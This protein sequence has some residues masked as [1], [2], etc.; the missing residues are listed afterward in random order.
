MNRENFRMRN[1][2]ELIRIDNFKK[3]AH[4]QI[5]RVFLDKLLQSTVALSRKYFEE[6][7]KSRGERDYP[8]RY[9]ERSIYSTFASALS[10]MTPLH[11]SELSVHGDHSK[12]SKGGRVDVWA[13]YR[14]TDFLL[15]I[16][17]TACSPTKGFESK[18]IKDS[19][20]SV[21]TQAKRFERQIAE[22]SDRYVLVGI[23]LVIAYRVS[24]IPFSHSM[25]VIPPEFSKE[26]RL[27]DAARLCRRLVDN[28]RTDSIGLKD[29][30]YCAI[31]VPSNE[32][33]IF[34]RENKGTETIP[35]VAFNVCTYVKQK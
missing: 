18:R 17:R 34:E 20:D 29:L 4:P 14:K 33:S 1:A 30:A 10:D 31:W 16:K 22:W 32:M 24:N 9:Q 7:V 8:L 23:Q 5:T 12:A 6:S 35:Y 11:L 26:A 19:W 28:G 25:R 2:G 13:N 3:G 27:K 15:E 21:S